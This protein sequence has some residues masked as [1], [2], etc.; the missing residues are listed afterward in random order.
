MSKNI[1]GK[2]AKYFHFFSFFLFLLI[3][4][5]GW[6]VAK[7][8]GIVTLDQIFFHLMAPLDGM[9]QE[10]VL[11]GIRYA[12]IFLLLLLGY[13]IVVFNRKISEK[14]ESVRL[15]KYIYRPSSGLWHICLGMF[16]IVTAVVFSEVKY[17]AVS[18]LFASESSFIKDNYAY[19]HYSDVR[20][21]QKNNAVVLILESM[22]NTYGDKQIFSRSLIPRLSEMQKENISFQ[23]QH[24]VYGTGWTIAGLTSYVFG[25]PLLLFKNSGNVLFDKFMPKADSV[26][27][28]L[29]HHGYALEYVLSSSA[30]FAG[31]DKMFHTHSKT[32]IQDSNYLIKHKNREMNGLWGVPDSFMYEWAKKRYAALLRSSQPFVL[33]VQSV[34]TH[35]YDG[36]I[37]PENNHGNGYRDVL[38]AA[39]IM[40]ADFIEWVKRQPGAEHTTII[41]LGDHLM[42]RCPLSDDYLTPH[43]DNRFIF[44]MFINALPAGQINRDRPC[45]S[46]DMAPTILESMGAVLPEH[47][48]GLGVSLF[49][50][51]KTLLEQMDQKALDAALKDKSSFYKS[52]FL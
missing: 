47:R 22:E 7:K 29:E 13:S 34:D 33:F 4:F 40:A 12:G 16:F 51:R 49:S 3:C 26:L 23:K 2:M 36:Y 15:V 20:F 44:N 27:G 1:A 37:E 25:V 19:C 42:G 17:H 28:I 10:L 8:F 24:Q 18:Y 5:C 11:W 48:L 30:V 52:L 32:F 21:V 9:D 6:R 45:T 31:T 50:S 14:L 38:K 41:V 46:F 35:G 39:D 43:S